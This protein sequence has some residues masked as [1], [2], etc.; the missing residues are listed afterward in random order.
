MKRTPRYLLARAA[1]YAALILGS[2]F[3]ALPFYWMISTSFQSTQESQSTIPTWLPNRMQ[4][5]AW[6][7]AW[8][9]GAQAGDAWW[10]GLQPGRSLEFEL[11][12]T[13]PAGARLPDPE[14]MF[15]QAIGFGEDPLNDY[16]AITVSE[17]RLEGERRVWT[18]RVENLGETVFHEVPL[19]ALFDRGYTAVGG[20]LPFDAERAQDAL[21]RYEW[22]NVA[23]GLLG[24]TLANYRDA[25]RA[26]PFG[27]YFFNSA[28]TAIT[29]TVL[30]L[31]VV[32]AA[33]FAFARIEFWGRD[34]L[35][36]V[37][38]ASL[39]IPGELLLVPNYVTVYRLGWTD[40]YAG[41]IV[42][43]IVSVF[44]IFLMRQFFLSLPNELF[45]ASLLDG[46]GYGTQLVRVALPLAVPGLV[47]F[48]LFSFLGSWNA[49]LWPLIVSNTPEFRTLQ[50]GLQAFIGEAG[51][52][53]GQLM[54]ASIITILPVILGFFLAQRQFI[55]G[56][57]RS[58]LK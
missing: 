7:G 50:V 40:S 46:A 4:P 41:L 30:G 52:E 56:V 35:F 25:L 26:A 1:L 10:G 57:A 6:A 31:I 58:G 21:A 8:T 13:A 22:D 20:T 38:L 23:P 44:G 48:G 33:A 9:L 17:P 29:Q 19:R 28:F 32:S 54:G 14:V 15:P 42:P 53:Y 34:V 36:A 55:A 39:M 43:W 47:T 2:V 24:Y 18:V 16:G 12:A 5:G 51:T 11:H 3:M 45:E 27:R 37:I 49:L